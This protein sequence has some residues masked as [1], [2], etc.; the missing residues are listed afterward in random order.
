MYDED[1]ED[2]EDEEQLQAAPIAAPVSALAY[3]QSIYCNPSEPEGRRLRAAVAALPFESP[4]LSATTIIN[5]ED[6]AD[7]LERSIERSGKTVE[8]RQIEPAPS[9]PAQGNDEPG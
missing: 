3:L 7:L 1:E 6:F 8:V 4:K 5:K 2:G 9:A